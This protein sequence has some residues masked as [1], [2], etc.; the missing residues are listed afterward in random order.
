[1]FCD[2]V[3]VSPAAEDKS[4]VNERNSPAIATDFFGLTH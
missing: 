3:S 1:M 4:E 2:L